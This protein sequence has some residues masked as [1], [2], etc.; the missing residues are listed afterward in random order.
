MVTRV[1]IRPYN[2]PA[3]TRFKMSRLALEWCTQRKALGLYHP[4]S[5]A[6]KARLRLT[7]SRAIAEGRIPRVSKLEFI[8]KKELEVLDLAFVHQKV[9]RDSHGRFVALPDFYLPDQNLVL[10]VNGTFWHADPREFPQGPLH[11]SQRRT[12]S[13][14]QTKMTLLAQLG[15][16]V[17]EVWEMDIRA[18]ARQAVIQALSPHLHLS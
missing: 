6:T 8:V 4:H 13:R 16:P 10:E 1:V 5:E 18:D 12:L 15:I 11:P 9:F 2:I 14:Y 17:A 3:A 7:T